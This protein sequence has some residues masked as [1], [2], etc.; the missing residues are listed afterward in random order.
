MSPAQPTA[1][2][3]PADAPARRAGP[4]PLAQMPGTPNA[5]ATGV[6]G[7]LG[8]GPELDQLGTV[9][10]AVG[11]G[12]ATAVLVAGEAGIGKSRLVEEFCDRARL[13]GAL[14]AVGRCTPA[15]AGLPYAPVMGILRDL[16]RQATSADGLLGSF[17][18]SSA[19]GTG[20]PDP[21]GWYAQLGPSAAGEFART[22]FFETLLNAVVELSAQ[23][24][25]ILVVEDLQWADSSSSDLVDFLVRNL[26]DNRVMV[27]GTY[28]SEEFGR[29]D[30]QAP[31]LTELVRHPRVV[32]LNLA[33]LSRV[34]VAALYAERTGTKADP[35]VLDSIFGRSQGNPFFTEELIAAGD[36]ATLPA[37]LSSVIMSRVDRLPLP[38]RRC[39]EVMAAV[40][41]FVDHA[42]A[43]RV[44]ALPGEELA[45]AIT[46][47]VHA[48]M[49]VVDGKENG[50]RFRHALLREA[51]YE[52]LLPPRRL[53]LHREIATALTEDPSLAA[54]A[55]THRSAE[56]AAHWWAAGEWAA[57]LAPSLDAIDAALGVCAFAEAFTCIERALAV[58]DKAPDAARAAGVRRADLLERGADVAY[59]AG[60]HER[61]VSLAEAAIEE[62]DAD[63]DPVAAARCYTLLGRNRWGVGDSGG[64]FDAYD[65][66]VALLPADEPSVELA[67][68]RAE[69]ARGYMLMSR[70]TLGV[71]YAQDAIDMARRIGARD[72]EGHAVNTLG[73]CRANMGLVDEG[74]DL[75]RQA[76]AIAEELNSPDDL[77]RAFGNLTSILLD[78]GQLEQAASVMLDSAAV[79]E[80]LWGVRLNGAA[81]NGVE[82]LV[83]LGRYAEAEAVLAQL[84]THSLGV[85]APGP[86]TMPTPMMIRRGRFDVAEALVATAREMTAQLK[87]VQQFASVLG[88]AAELALERARPDDAW[89]LAEQALDLAM[90]SDDEVLLPELCVLGTRAI[91]DMAEIASPQ[92]RTERVDR[93]RARSD[94]LVAAVAGVEQTQLARGG[95]PSP[96]L[97]ACVVATAAERSRLDRSDPEL[98]AEAVRR[99]E[100]STEVYPLAYSLWREAEAVV[101]A[102]GSRAHAADLLQR[103][104]GIA[105]QLD[106]QPLKS[107]M[108]ALAQRGRVDLRAETMPASGAG[109]SAADTL[110]LTAREVEVLGQ[111]AAGKSDREIGEALYIS[112]KTVSVHVSNVLRKL[113]VANR[114]E[115]GKIAHAHG[116]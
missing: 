14:V 9:Y 68:L 87:D 116:L 7:L 107:R 22:V 8:R 24:P 110:G 85:C 69:Q 101:E 3:R 37:A 81:G 84:G 79:G 103:A 31:W 43:A 99:W 54:S 25:V 20:T 12:R 72:I 100:R 67:R 2:N 32:Q 5:P 74:L 16:A 35:A 61:A 49:V 29:D 73:C 53:Q 98:W 95:Q 115:A 94:E 52:S 77:N 10:D 91:A 113:S 80:E 51:V 63:A 83:R 23:A 76:L 47:A 33:G 104:W 27:V 17:A 1:T 92:D 38:A 111:I 13:A 21:S 39:L 19:T 62:I 15:G 90:S 65:T 28:R 46:T 6:A 45:Q 59:F 93:W 11:G 41:A 18:A 75:L 86:W 105:V 70:N 66:A 42:L 109:T 78:D 40:G 48:N 26:G 4:G 60:A 44:I 57:A 71:E 55:P 30:P 89:S 102:K 64:V 106:A 97:R 34:D 36:P 58:F 56:I 88:D 82:A 50:Y 114:V 96:R 112:R 108:I